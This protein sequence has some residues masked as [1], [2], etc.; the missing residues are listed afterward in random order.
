MPTG[1]SLYQ[2]KPG[3]LVREKE[4]F[5]RLVQKLKDLAA[6]RGYTKPEIASEIFLFDLL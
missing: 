6:E 5:G 4:E 1:N 2:R 3:R